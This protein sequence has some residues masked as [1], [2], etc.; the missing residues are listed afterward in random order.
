MIGFKLL[1]YVILTAY[2]I[3]YRMPNFMMP[4]RVDIATVAILAAVACTGIATIAASFSTLREVPATL[5]RP[6]APKAG[7]RVLIERI[8]FIW[9]RLNFT[10]KVTVRNI[11]R[12]K[13]RF[14]MSIIGIAGS[15]SLLV[16]GFGIEDSIFGIAEYQFE[17]IWK[18]DI[19]AYTYDSM[20]LAEIQSLA[21][22]S[23]SAEYFSSLMFCYDSVCDAGS[24]DARTGNVHL[25]GVRDYSEMEGKIQLH[26]G[27]VEI[28]L[29]DDGAVITKK[30]SEITGTQIGDTLTLF[31]GSH[32]YEVRVAG[33][34]DNYVYHYVYMT[35][36]YYEQV[37]GKTMEY[38]AF[39]INLNCAPEEIEG[40]SEAILTDS[41]VYTVMTLT[42]I[43]DTIMDSL[44]ILDYIVIVL[45]AGSALLTFVV[46]LNL[47]N[48]NLEERKRELA[49]LRVLGFYDREMYDYIFREN[50]ALAVL[51]AA[52]GLALGKFMHAFIIRTCEVDIVMFVRS[53]NATS[54][55]YAFVL[56]VGFSLCVN[57][58]M[59]RKV[60]A[61]D[62]VESL[63]SAE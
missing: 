45:I 62:M 10:M 58:M 41:R 55:L 8:G 37:T 30:L 7:K 29:T 39:M 50:N 42:S 1:P 32:E 49:T 54:F 21:E 12:Y 25:M 51:G 59:R 9:K 47:T 26:S 36:A 27:G 44:G 24:G 15:C 14:F 28:P 35:A 3:M 23:P 11:F 40:V 13:K 16:T 22:E 4:Y 19:Q 34:A 31:S 46:M 43:Y 61:I 33:I 60:R 2:S 20:P 57:L 6:K 63:K 48:I 56:T 38:N 5:M 18:M 17:D 52:V 53:I